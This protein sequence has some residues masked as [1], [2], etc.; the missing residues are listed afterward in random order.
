[1]SEMAGVTR[2]EIPIG[3]EHVR[4]L[5]QDAIALQPKNGG[6]KW[7]VTPFCIANDIANLLALSRLL[8][9]DPIH[10]GSVDQSAL[11]SRVAGKPIGQP[12]H[13]DDC[14]T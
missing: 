1:M 11:R 9:S 7:P 6:P 3:P 10:L 12:L 8:R 2:N 14:T 4:V 13:Q 5:I